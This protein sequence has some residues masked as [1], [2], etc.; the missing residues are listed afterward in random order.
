MSLEPLGF[1]GLGRMGSL[2][3]ARLAAADWPLIAFDA[4]GTQQRLPPVASA[5]TSVADLAAR[6][7]LVLLSLPDGAASTSVCAEPATAP[8]RRALAA[9]RRFSPTGLAA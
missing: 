5:A 9:T 1:V 4:A 3:A 6:A 8:H 2:M 7:D